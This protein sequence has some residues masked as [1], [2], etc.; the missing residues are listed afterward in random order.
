MS[1]RIPAQRSPNFTILN[2]LFTISVS[3]L[4]RPPGRS[5]GSS[6]SCPESSP[7]DC[8]AGYSERDSQSC[9]NHHSV[10][11]SHDCLEANS[12]N[13]SE[14]CG[15]RRRAG[16]SS[17]CSENSLAIS[18]EGSLQGYPP[19]CSDGSPGGY[20]ADCLV[21]ALPNSSACPGEK[22][23]GAEAPLRYGLGYGLA[24]Q[25]DFAPGLTR[26]A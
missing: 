12:V 2:S 16:F 5:R 9:L 14:S 24:G 19:N 18:S 13:S 17:G 22:R 15:T 3:H 6:A 1:H 25:D 23:S 8:Y 4:S 10:S 7:E 11:Y 20:S 21:D 26:L